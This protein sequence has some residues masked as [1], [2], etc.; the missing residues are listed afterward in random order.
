MKREQSGS[1]YGSVRKKYQYAVMG[2]FHFSRESKWTWFYKEILCIYP[3]ADTG[4]DE[5][6]HTMRINVSSHGTN[7]LTNLQSPYLIK[8][9][10]W[11]DRRK[12]LIQPLS[13]FIST[14]STASHYLRVDRPQTNFH[15]RRTCKSLANEADIFCN[16]SMFPSPWLRNSALHSADFSGKKKVLFHWMQSISLLYSCDLVA[17]Y[18]IVSKCSLLIMQETRASSILFSTAAMLARDEVNTVTVPG[19]P[20]GRL[21]SVSDQWNWHVS[22]S[23]LRDALW[24]NTVLDSTLKV[25]GGT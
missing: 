11:R 18:M 9:R 14:S 22:S 15:H 6:Q 20:Y 2:H 13:L 16:D 25:V 10:K 5:L 21:L 8:R 3:R 1:S 23:N 7:S 19:V 24:R 17:N 12:N 4:F